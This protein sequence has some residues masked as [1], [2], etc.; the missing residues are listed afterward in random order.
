MEKNIN[1]FSFDGSS[2]NRFI[3]PTKIDIPPL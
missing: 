1:V 2:N 3:D